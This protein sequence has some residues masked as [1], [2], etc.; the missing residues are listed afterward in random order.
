[1]RYARVVE[2]LTPF[3]GGL[4]APAEILVP[5]VLDERLRA[6][7][8]PPPGLVPKAAAVLVL[9]YPDE[10]GE[11]R[12]VLTERATRDGHHS[13]EVSLPGG[14]A[15]AGD[16]GPAGT[17]LREAAEEVALDAVAAGVRILGELEK[18]WI[19]VSNFEVTPV[20]A[21]ADRP[22]SLHPSEAEVARIVHAP[23]EG[24][25]PGA[26]VDV[27]ERR[28]GEWPLRYGAYPVEGLSVWGATARILSQLGAL[29]GEPVRPAQA[30][31]S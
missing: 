5:V 23:L 27:V 13:G 9:V 21:L 30:R 18:F 29:V 15:E 25:V 26:P 22:P 19:P 12:V 14:R 28:I 4:P 16:D 6:T 17:A 2:R 7:R 1:V 3:P 31:Q 8:V 24:F 10:S 11:A 20:V